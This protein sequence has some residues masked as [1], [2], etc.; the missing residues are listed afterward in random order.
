MNTRV[1]AQSF[2]QR[3]SSLLTIYLFVF[4]SHPLVV[5]RNALYM[6][7]MHRSTAK[8]NIIIAP[9]SHFCFSFAIHL[10][11]EFAKGIVVTG[12]GLSPIEKLGFPLIYIKCRSVNI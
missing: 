10:N 12:I 2:F 11:D 7:I 1:P 5:R 3:C 4:L 9:A 8:T 6:P